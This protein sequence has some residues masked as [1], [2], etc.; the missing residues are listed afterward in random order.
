[1]SD[2]SPTREDVIARMH[3]ARAS[4]E[5]L[6]EGWDEARLL[7]KGPEGWSIKDHLAHLVPWMGGI[8]ALLRR[9]DRWTAMGLTQAQ[10]DH[11]PGEEEV[12][13]I[14]HKQWA[15]TSLGE[16]RTALREAHEELEGV[17]RRLKDE[18]L[19]RPYDYYGTGRTEPGDTRPIVGW[20][21]GNSYD[22]LD[23]HRGW[24]E[25]LARKV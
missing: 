9:E 8:S 4:L 19:A 25:E 18:D 2:A 10:L 14:L 6:V 5:A 17:I 22:H 7:A 1:M 3:V 16:V 11:E 13:D 15:G 20:I 23:E 24:I 21:A 12:N